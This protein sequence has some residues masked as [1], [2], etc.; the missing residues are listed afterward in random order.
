V[1]TLDLGQTYYWKVKEANT[2][3]PI[4]SW[5]SDVWDFTTQDSYLVDGFET[6]NDNKDAGLATWQTWVDGFGSSDNGSQVG[7]SPAPY[8]EK[9]VVH[10][11]KQ[12]LP[13]YYN[14]VGSYSHSEAVRTFETAQDW[15]RGGAKALVLYFQGL[16]E[17]T[18]GQL[19]VKINGTKVLYD[20]AEND[21]AKP[22]WIQC[23]IDLA[24]VGVDLTQVRTLIIGVDNGGFGTLFID[25]IRL[26]RI[27][28]QQAREEVWVEA[29]AADSMVGP[30]QIYSDR[31]D[32][33]GGQ[34][35]ATIGDNS[36]G[37]PPENE[38]VARYTVRLAGGT[39]RIIGR[40]ITPTV[41][42]DSFWVH[43]EGAT[44]NTTNDVSGWIRWGLDV[45]A[46]W[47]DVP[48]RSLDDA[49][50]NQTVL[51]TVEPGIYN[52]EIA[53][54]EDGALLDAWMITKQLQ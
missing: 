43:F 26:Y 44:T 1:D 2:A 46:T 33:S 5:Q 48:V 34:Y 51:F 14:N 31:P 11:G 7:H 28:P 29:E 16:A 32:A 37:E 4:T 23:T 25:D 52:L 15:T 21:L 6:Y 39:Y 22:F 45:S 27:A 50:P 19:Y 35:I 53:Y 41:N 12:S 17:N 24:K 42:D 10:S 13:L 36:T 49:N 8:A 38:G 18:A 47:H 40:V 54:R 3:E 9:I 30:M 20:G